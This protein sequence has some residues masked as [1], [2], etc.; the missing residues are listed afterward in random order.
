MKLPSADIQTESAGML[1]EEAFGVGNVG[2]IFEILRNKMYKNPIMAIAREITCNARDAHREVGTPDRPIEINLPNAF[3]PQ[4]KVRDFGPGISPERMSKVFIQYATSTKRNDNFQTGGFGLGAKT[5]FS[6]SDTFSIITITDGVK[7]T[8]NAYIDE[9]RVGKM[10]LAL[11]QNT[12]EPNG[13]TIVVPVFKKDFQEFVTST[14]TSTEYWDVKPILTGVSPAPKY[15]DNKIL[16]TGNQWS[17]YRKGTG[18]NTGYTGYGY[19]NGDNSIA[20][21]DG[22]GYKIESDSIA[23]LTPFHKTLL[24]NPFLFYFGNGELSLSASRDSIHYDDKTQQFIIER[25]KLLAKEVI[26]I[27]NDKIQKCAGYKEAC[28]LYQQTLAEFSNPAQL[29]EALRGILWH[30]QKILLDPQSTNIGK[31]AKLTTYIVKKGKV[32]ADRYTYKISYDDEN[33]LFHN[34]KSD[35]Q[36]PKKLV[37]YVFA[38]QSTVKMVQVVTTPKEPDAYDYIDAVK[39]GQKPVV[40]YNMKLLEMMGAEKISTI[41]IPKAKIVRKPRGQ[42]KTTISA[43]NFFLKNDRLNAKIEE[44]PNTGGI[45][46]EADYKL[47]IY[48]SGKMKIP[49][50]VKL[51]LMESF[52][53]KKVYGFSKDRIKKLSPQW[54]TLE[55]AIESKIKEMESEITEQ[56]L[57]DDCTA[58]NW[59]FTYCFSDIHPDLK[60]YLKN[61]SKKSLFLEYVTESERV[62]KVIQTY[63]SYIYILQMMGKDVTPVYDKYRR[64]KNKTDKTKLCKLLNSVSS[65]Y[66][67]LLMLHQVYKETDLKNMLSY[68]NLVDEHEEGK[69]SALKLKQIA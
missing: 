38:T 58:S 31:W 62:E 63:K 68:I 8:Y 7:R 44:V 51:S 34:D 49:S 61:L 59:L 56:S 24:S 40:E 37:D 60:K 50:N 55:V 52:L 69:T 27:I 54:I 5:P 22:I 36:I 12:D 39:K 42:N 45:Y 4:F 16:Y 29:S 43:Y 23:G 19:N 14:I 13:T 33:R 15:K 35:S 6:Y 21:I 64:D 3:A 46:I 53:G 20:V 47:K 41:V 66:P 28:V 26:Q 48:N 30:G 10:A 25:M 9:T 32:S 1:L 57:M 2:L 11:E 17:L 65:Q 18:P 67:L